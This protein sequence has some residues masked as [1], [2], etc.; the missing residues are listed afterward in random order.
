MT[1]SD[2][3]GFSLTIASKLAGWADDVVAVLGCSASSSFSSSSDTDEEQEEQELEWL[4]RVDED[5]EGWQVADVDSSAAASFMSGR[6]LAVDFIR[7]SMLAVIFTE[8][9]APSLQPVHC[10]FA[11][12]FPTMKT[13]QS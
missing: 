3:V 8:E 1:M 2:M 11:G 13:K 5:D 12:V 4:A 9:A 6:T 10:R 7:L